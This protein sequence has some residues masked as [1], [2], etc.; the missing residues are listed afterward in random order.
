MSWQSSGV[1]TIPETAPLRTLSR[2]REAA[3]VA[4]GAIAFAAI[5]CWPILTNLT[6]AGVRFDWDF[7]LTPVWAGYYSIVHFHQFPFWN[8]YECGGVP[9]FADPQARLFTP[10]FLLSLLFGPIVGVHLEV[11]IHLAIGWAGGYVLGRVLGMRPIGALCTACAFCGSSWFFLHVAEGHMVFVPLM[12]TPWIVAFA[13][14]AVDRRRLSWAILGG[15]LVAITVGEGGVYAATYQMIVVV[16]VMGAWAVLS[17]SLWP[18]WATLLTGI[19]SL[20]FV[21]IK[22]APA[23]AFYIRFPRPIDSPFWTDFSIL[24]IALFSH[25][26]DHARAGLGWGFHEYGAYIGLFTVPAIIG[27]FRPR[28]AIPWAVA[29]LILFL[30]ALGDISPHAPWTVLHRLPMFRSERLPSRLLMPF[31]LMIAVLAGFGIDLLW[32]LRNY[33]GKLIAV[34][35]L[36]AGTADGFIV[37]TPN[38]RY[39]FGYP[40]PRITH[41]AAFRQYRAPYYYVNMLRTG[42]ANEGAIQCYEYTAIPTSVIGYNQPGYQGEQHLIDSGSVTLLRWSPNALSYR[43]NASIPTVLVINQNYF[44]S[45][46]LSKG[47]GRVIEY[48]NLLAIKIPAGAQQLD[49]YYFDWR[50]MLGAVETLLTIIAALLLWRGE[51][52]WAR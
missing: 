28:R 21:A 47:S 25:N 36:V 42:L 34:A 43:V 17:T 2:R 9:L 31:V 35:L 49:L 41:H 45:W 40:L 30:L 8:P 19:F 33:W 46:R 20:G 3:L 39:A 12:Y 13:W 15:A 26:Q 44:P 38:L 52:P 14:L 48:G 7:T 51:I 32:S 27:L 22:L 50:F 16:L 24:M 29:A 23:I 10:F 37:S 6:V 18:L 11:P 4:A 5:F 1:E